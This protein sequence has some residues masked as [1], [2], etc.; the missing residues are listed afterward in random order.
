MTRKCSD[1]GG[2]G[3]PCAWHAKRR[4]YAR[5]YA[6]RTRG[7]V[8][9]AK[10]LS[11]RTCPRRF[12]RFGVCG[13]VLESD[14]VEGCLVVRCPAC[15]RFARGICRDCPAPVEGGVRKA[16]RCARCKVA[17]QMAAFHKYVDNNRT[18]VRR[19]ARAYYRASE[20]RRMRRNEYKRLYRA[21]HPEKVREQKRREALKQSATAAAYRAAYRAKKK[22]ERDTIAHERTPV[23]AALRT[24]STPG[25]DIV[26]THK[27]KKCTRCKETARRSA[28]QIIATRFRTSR[29]R[30]A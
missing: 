23:A 5:N 26:V 30:A 21:A 7:A 19:R 18:E 28:E 3:C 13:A 15:E 8:I 24:C 27:K 10:R 11:A 14:V 1:R 29:P 2:R 6:R 17:A 25:C 4:A 16:R 22:A 9:A 12:G 20:E